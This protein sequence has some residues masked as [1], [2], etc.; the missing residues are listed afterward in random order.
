MDQ[1]RYKAAVDRT[2]AKLRYSAI[3]LDNLRAVE[4]KGDD[5]ERSYQESFLFHLHGVRDA[6]LQEINI[7]YNCDLPIEKVK[8][9]SLKRKISQM[10]LISVALDKLNEIESDENSWLSH[11]NEMR[12]HSAHRHTIPR[13]HHMGGENHGKIHL[14]NTKNGEFISEDYFTLFGQWQSNMS[15]LITQLRNL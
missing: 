6:F 5:F 10:G 7:K 3:H 4:K 11:L 1:D 8:M 15:E 2:A 14:A 12:N 13:L 9:Q